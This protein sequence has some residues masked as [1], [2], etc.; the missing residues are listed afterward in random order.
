MKGKIRISVGEQ[1]EWLLNYPVH[2][3]ENEMEKYNSDFEF[4]YF[5]GGHFI[6]IFSEK[7]Q[8]NGIKF[9]ENKY[10]DYINHKSFK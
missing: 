5:S 8:M 9:L 4:E 3:L 10:Y 2:L 6:Y 7:Y 1:D